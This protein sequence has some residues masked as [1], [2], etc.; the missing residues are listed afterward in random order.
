MSIVWKYILAAMIAYMLGSFSTGLIVA[1]INHGPDLRSVGSQNTGASNVLRTM[2]VKWGLITF[3]G[4]FIK[5]A[6]SC[7]IGLWLTGE[8]YG[9]MLAGLMCIIGHNW[10]VF[11]GFKG[12]KGVASSCGVM[13]ICFPI[14]AV[15]A[16]AVAILVIALTKYISL[17]SLS[18]LTVFAVITTCFYSRGDVLIILWALLLAVLCF[19][20]HKKNIGRLL[21]HTEIKIGEKA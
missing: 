3:W 4:D 5:A 10:P 12:G 18:M 20:R 6:L 21:N 16:Y 8:I 1:R 7:L 15:I 2:G 9:A 19:L 17:G 14:P 13:V 11:F